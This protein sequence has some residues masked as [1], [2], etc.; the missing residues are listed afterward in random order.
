MLPIPRSGA[1]AAWMSVPVLMMQSFLA[2]GCTTFTI[3]DHPQVPCSSSRFAFHSRRYMIQ[4]AL[5]HRGD[6]RNQTES[7]LPYAMSAKH[8]ASMCPIEELLALIG[9]RWKPVILWWLIDSR[10]PLRFKVLRQN[11]PRISQKV[12]AQQ[13]RELERDGLIKREMFAE[14]PVRVEYSPTL[15]GK[16]LRNVLRVLDAWSRKHVVKENAPKQTPV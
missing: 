10:K 8:I 14:M 11:M 12:L 7:W 1:S 9:G 16:K 3:P 5:Y 13:L 15:F 6:T 4:S 2:A